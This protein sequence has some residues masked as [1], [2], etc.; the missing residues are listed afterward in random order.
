MHGQG[1]FYDALIGGTYHGA[2]SY[3]VLQAIR[4]ANYKLT[5]NQ[6]HGRLTLLIMDGGDPQH[7]QLKGNSAGRRRQIF[8]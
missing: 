2:M 1:V 8:T 7:P 3:Y 5:C 4:E 6:V